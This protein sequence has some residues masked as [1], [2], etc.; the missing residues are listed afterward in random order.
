MR[1]YIIRHGKAVVVRNR[2]GG[3]H[4]KSVHIWFDFFG[5]PYRSVSDRI[6]DRRYDR[7]FGK[8]R[9][10]RRLNHT[11]RREDAEL[12]TG[13][14]IPEG[15]P[16]VWH[17]IF[18]HAPTTS[19]YATPGLTLGYKDGKLSFASYGADPSEAEDDATPKPRKRER[20]P[21]SM[22]PTPR[23]NWIGSARLLAN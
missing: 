5:K 19:I 18:E 15:M 23:R 22:R 12:L 7:W 9:M 1:T 6:A 20:Q 3:Q 13:S 14:S 2:F 21:Q 17:T 8:L 10:N 4:R 11:T 16:L